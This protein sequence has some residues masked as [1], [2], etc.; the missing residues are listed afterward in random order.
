MRIAGLAA[1]LA[2]AACLACTPILDAIGDDGLPDA[3]CAF[4]A[5]TEHTAPYCPRVN[6]GARATA[7][8]HVT[9][10]EPIDPDLAR[11]LFARGTDSPIRTE[12]AAAPTSRRAGARPEPGLRSHAL[13]GRPRR[14]CVPQ[15]PPYPTCHVAPSRP[16]C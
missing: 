14:H 13:C 6:A 12:A 15:Q 11:S 3:P 5:S 10:G 4:C 16:S 9:Q 7:S 8:H 1:V 2:A